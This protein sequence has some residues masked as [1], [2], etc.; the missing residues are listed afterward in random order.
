MGKAFSEE[1]RA[2]VQESLRR[3]GLRLFAEKGM[4]GVS[5]R[6]LTS[7]AGIAQGGFY[8][9]Y[10]DKE[11]FLI[12]LMAVRVE[13]KLVIIKEQRAES[14]EN[15]TDYIVDIFFTQGMH[16][17][18]NKAFDNAVSGTLELFFR[19]ESKMSARIGGLYRDYFEF[20]VRYWKENGYRVEADIDGL[21]SIVRVAGVLFSNASLIGEDYFGEIYKTFCRAEVSRFLRVSR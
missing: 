6:E 1:E 4:R 3:I 2:Q 16:L 9:F 14:L 5:I 11:D 15:P 21:M 7:K 20:M 8:T 12:D 19:T 10:E 18:E 17:K 13:E